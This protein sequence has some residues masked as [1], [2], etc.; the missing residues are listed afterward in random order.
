MVFSMW[1]YFYLYGHLDLAFII[2]E[3]RIIASTESSFSL[4]DLL[5][6]NKKFLLPNVSSS[7]VGTGNL[8][9]FSLMLSFLS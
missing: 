4:P 1:K 5:H 9:G 6:E 3:F 8:L 7:E 2:F